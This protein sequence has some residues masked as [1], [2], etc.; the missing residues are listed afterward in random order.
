[1][2]ASFLPARTVPEAASPPPSRLVRAPFAIDPSADRDRVDRPSR[3]ISDPFLAFS[4]TTF[5]LIYT[6]SE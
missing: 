1:M 2:Q 6:M 3:S 5:V 4:V